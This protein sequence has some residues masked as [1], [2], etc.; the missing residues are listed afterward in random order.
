MTK[1]AYQRIF[2]T[3]IEFLIFMIMKKILFKAL[4]WLLSVIRAAIISGGIFGL[5]MFAA[6]MLFDVNTSDANTYTVPGIIVIL[7]FLLIIVNDSSWV[8]K[9]YTS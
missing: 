5:Y 7:L 2:C 3:N 8:N 9:E 1:S 6:V 4:L